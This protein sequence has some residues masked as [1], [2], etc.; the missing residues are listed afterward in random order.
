MAIQGRR[1]EWP[2]YKSGSSADYSGRDGIRPEC[3]PSPIGGPG[4]HAG[5]TLFSF[6]RLLGAVGDQ[7]WDRETRR[8]VIENI[9][10]LRGGWV[11]RRYAARAV[12]GIEIIQIG[13]HGRQRRAGLVALC[14]GARA[15]RSSGRR[16]IR[17]IRQA[18]PR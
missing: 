8:D 11:I 15:V 3:L 14:P 17:L 13:G 7:P 12:I 2:S 1:A 9:D 18:S 4:R 5:L 6:K 16:T 10:Q